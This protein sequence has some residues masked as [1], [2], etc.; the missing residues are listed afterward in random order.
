MLLHSEPQKCTCAVFVRRLQA[1]EPYWEKNDA[2]TLV[3]R[4]LTVA[5]ITEWKEAKVILWIT[6]VFF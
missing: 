2:Y 4:V 5:P 1:D 6:S 3:D